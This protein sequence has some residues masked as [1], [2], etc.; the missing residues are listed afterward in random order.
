[1]HPSLLHHIPS[2][3]SY[4]SLSLVSSQEHQSYDSD[5]SHDNDD[6]EPCLVAVLLLVQRLQKYADPVRPH[7]Q[8]CDDEYYRY[9]YPAEALK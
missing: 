5:D 8:D 4:F 7:Y 1:M 6:A 3:H 9:F 2:C